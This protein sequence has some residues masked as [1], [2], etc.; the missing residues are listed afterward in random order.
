MIYK[1][2]IKK[3]RILFCTSYF[4]GFEN[5]EDIE[6]ESKLL[7]GQQGWGDKSK[8]VI[9]NEMRDHGLA[10]CL[11]VLS[12]VFSDICLSFREKASSTVRQP[13]AAISREPDADAPGTHRLLPET[14]REEE[15][16]GL[17]WF[18]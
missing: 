4:A 1:V 13:A 2:I 14:D 18:R 11:Y 6:E 17:R 3:E 5:E 10:G 16:D 12:T 7:T 8:A 15:A 9:P